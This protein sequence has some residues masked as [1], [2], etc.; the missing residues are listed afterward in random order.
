M[1]A[2]LLWCAGL[3]RSAV[4][5]WTDCFIL[6]SKL[7]SWTFWFWYHLLISVK[8]WLPRSECFLFKFQLRLWIRH[9]HCS[10][11]NKHLLRYRC[12]SLIL[13]HLCFICRHY[14][15]LLTSYFLFLTFDGWAPGTCILILMIHDSSRGTGII[16]S[17]STFSPHPGRVIRDLFRH[18]HV[19]WHGTE[20]LVYSNHPR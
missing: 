11:N 9:C 4:F 20:A 10:H 18:F 8:N 12:C 17:S 7:H 19:V 16:V 5:L 6:L 14:S 13:F 3:P 2:G 15:G 1:S